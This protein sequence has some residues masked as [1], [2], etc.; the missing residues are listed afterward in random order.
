MY[1]LA[2][3]IGGTKTILAI[4]RGNKK[5]FYRKYDSRKFKNLESLVKRF[6]KE[7]KLILDVELTPKIV[8]IVAV[9]NLDHEIDLPNIAKK[10]GAEFNPIEFPRIV[11]KEPGM[12]TC[13]IFKTGKILILGSKSIKKLSEISLIVQQKLI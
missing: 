12:P 3:D 7:S 9:L 8:N 13:L 2:G 6:L 11:W 10:L 4:F 1:T 5:V